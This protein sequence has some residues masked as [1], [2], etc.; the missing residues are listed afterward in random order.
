MSSPYI[1]SAVGSTSEP[2]DHESQKGLSD[3]EGEEHGR[4]TRKRKS[5]AVSIEHSRDK[6]A[7]A[8]RSR[9]ARGKS[10]QRDFQVAVSALIKSFPLGHSIGEVTTSN[11]LRKLLEILWWSILENYYRFP[12]SKISSIYENNGILL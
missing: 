11:H 6:V 5:V 8:N 7:E 10:S 1:A 3:W 2:A 12:P 4:F 9:K